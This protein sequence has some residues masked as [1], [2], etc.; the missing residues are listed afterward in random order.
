MQHP[1]KICQS[2]SSLCELV[3]LL[4]MAVVVKGAFA[5]AGVGG[6]NGSSVPGIW[7]REI[8][9]TEVCYLTLVFYIS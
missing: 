4:A 5:G 3:L 7:R 1:V 6:T 9:C 8:T 2:Q